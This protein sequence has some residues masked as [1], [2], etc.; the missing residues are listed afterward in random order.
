MRVL[1]MA[2]NTVRGAL[3][4][5]VSTT[6]QQSVPAQLEALREY[7]RRRGWEVVQEV[8]EVGSGAKSRPKR[9]ALLEAARRRE[10]DAIA[11]VQLARW[12]R[13]LSD[14]VVTLQEL[15]E[16][17]VQFASVQDSLDFGT[18]AGRALAG[19]LSVFAAFERDLL[20]ERVK[21][22]LAHAQRHGTRSGKAIGRPATA[23][24]RTTEIRALASQGVS[25]AETARRLGLGYGSVHRVLAA[26]PA[27][28]K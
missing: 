11:V 23:R 22:G 16:L 27:R 3:Y 2:E 15:G 25:M 24:A 9:E 1:D 4:A 20:R 19:M 8:A 6:G 28:H 12:G 13:S 17:G 10:I 18:P 21:S 26:T 7:A 5:R 14:L